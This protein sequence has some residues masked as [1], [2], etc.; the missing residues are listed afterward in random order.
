MA[1][2]VFA[3]LHYI[4]QKKYQCL[5]QVCAIKGKIIAQCKA[6]ALFQEELSEALENHIETGGDLY[7]VLFVS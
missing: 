1:Q 2:V 5:R 3:L 6:M 7:Y 4:F